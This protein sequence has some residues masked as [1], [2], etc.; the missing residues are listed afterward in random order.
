MVRVVAD[1]KVIDV[2][3]LG[4]KLAGNFPKDSAKERPWQDEGDSST[5]FDRSTT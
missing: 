3:A 2:E 5:V 1:D 4:Q